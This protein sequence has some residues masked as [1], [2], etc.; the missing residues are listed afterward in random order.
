MKQFLAVFDGYKVSDST[1]DYVVHLSKSSGAHL[2]G[3]FLDVSSRL[4]HNLSNMVKKEYHSDEL[5]DV[6][7]EQDHQMS[8]A[9]AAKFQQAC[10]ANDIGFSIIKDENQSLQELQ[11]TG[12]FADLVFINENQTLAGSGTDSPSDFVKELLAH[13]HCPVLVLPLKFSPIQKIVFLYDGSPASVYAIKMFCYLFESFKEFPV[14]VFTVNEDDCTQTDLPEDRLM[15][16]FMASRF[17]NFSYTSTNGI[18]S[19]EI[20]RYF[21]KNQNNSLVV[22]GAYQRSKISR[23]LKRSLADELIINFD[24]PLFIAHH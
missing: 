14:T 16:T 13:V 3:M 18:P 19:T 20:R 11:R 15:L 10:K 22:L 2:T 17:A 1:L 7:D 12:T 6:L 4:R 24:M 23:M 9:A 8:A 5:I 21:Q